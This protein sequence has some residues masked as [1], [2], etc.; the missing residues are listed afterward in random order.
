MSGAKKGNKYGNKESVQKSY[1]SFKHN[2][3]TKQGYI[4]PL[5]YLKV[6][7]LI[8]KYIMEYLFTGQELP[9]PSRLGALQIVKYKP[10]RNPVN[11]GATNKYNKNIAHVNY[12]SDGYCV[13]MHWDK[14]YHNANFK[15]KQ[16]WG[17]DLSKDNKSRRE[18]S[19]AQHVKRHGVNKFLERYKINY[20]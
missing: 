2:D 9:L 14:T 6:L 13:R 4:E 20:G 7:R 8:S 12:H 19:I 17:F 10:N 16:L 5:M 15:N 3:K 18:S 1:K 11:F